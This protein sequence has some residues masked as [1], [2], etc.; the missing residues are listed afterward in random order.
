[1]NVAEQLDKALRVAGL[2]IVGVSI[3]DPDTRW[4]WTVQPADLQ[5]QAQPIIDALDLSVADP[6]IRNTRDLIG[7]FTPTEWGQLK[8]LIAQ[9]DDATKQ[10]FDYWVSDPDTDLRS[11]KWIT[12]RHALAPLLWP[13]ATVRA[14]RIAAI[15]A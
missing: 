15:E 10:D 13:D 2:A 11:Q 9:A 12:R 6:K 14:A 4:T 8:A 7:R 5:A 1:M 3:G